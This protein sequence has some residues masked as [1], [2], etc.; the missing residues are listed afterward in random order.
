MTTKIFEIDNLREGGRERK[1]EEHGEEKRL[2]RA[3]I[4]IS[5]RNKG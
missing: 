4:S 3:E 5:K 1:K 2:K